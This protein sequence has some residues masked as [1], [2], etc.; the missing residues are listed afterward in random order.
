MLP[1][2]LLTVDLY[3]ISQ[4][5]LDLVRVGL[6]LAAFKA[7]KGAYPE[8]LDAIAGDVKPMPIDRFSGGPL[9][10]A[11]RGDGFILY[12]V[13]QNGRDEGGLEPAPGDHKAADIVL[14]T[15]R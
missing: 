7:E 1:D 13:G 9:K 11:R 2:L 4:Q 12:G 8:T 15:D 14:T 3:H 5:R 10:Y 6:A